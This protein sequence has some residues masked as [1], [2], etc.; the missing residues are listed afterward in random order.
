MI[1]LYCHK[2]TGLLTNAIAGG[3]IAN[4]RAK[5]NTTLERE[6]VFHDG[7][8][9]VTLDAAA[10][11]VFVGKTTTNGVP[12]GALVI[13]DVEW[14]PTGVQ[15][16][17]YIFR[18]PLWGS[19]LTALATEDNGSRIVSCA[20]HFTEPTRSQES[21][22]FTVTVEPPVFDEDETPEDP[23]PPYPLPGEI[24]VKTGN[25]SGLANKAA[26]RANLDISIGALINKVTAPANS[27]STG[28]VGDFAV[29]TQYLYFYTGD[30]TTHT[31]LRVA[32][33][34]EF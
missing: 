32:G 7:T 23:D 24:L 26:A 28:A 1:K 20:V 31:W 33:A 4:L 8:S 9:I 5:L 19:A 29:S 14:E 22:T 25:L 10:A 34:N 16:G 27:T 15:G 21:Q 11:G 2:D 6:I 13:W 18:V 3:A 30:G 12:T 17:G